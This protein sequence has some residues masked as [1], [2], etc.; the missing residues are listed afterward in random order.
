[1]CNKLV[2]ILLIACIGLA[3]CSSTAKNRHRIN[4][5]QTRLSSHT[6]SPQIE[7]TL[8]TDL[9][10]SKQTAEL[11]RQ[12]TQSTTKRHVSFKPSSTL[13]DYVIVTTVLCI[14]ELMLTDQCTSPYYHVGI[15]HR[16]PSTPHNN[17][18]GY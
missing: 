4:P 5:Q 16:Y 12:T 7:E 10:M 9:R 2:S 18:H 13:M 8:I 15:D 11:E 1:M 6:T 17:T 3:G 14:I